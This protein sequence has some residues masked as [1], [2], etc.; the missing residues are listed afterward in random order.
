MAKRGIRKRRHLSKPYRV[1]SFS[2]DTETVTLEQWGDAVSIPLTIRTSLIHE[3]LRLSWWQQ[4][5]ALMPG[6][7]WYERER[8]TQGPPFRIP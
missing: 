5:Y 8:Q 1:G 2:V 7:I 3:I 4:P 6:A